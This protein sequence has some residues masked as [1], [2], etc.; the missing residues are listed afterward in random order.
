M[1]VCLLS[2][3]QKMMESLNNEIKM[4]QNK[5]NPESSRLSGFFSFLYLFLLFSP[6]LHDLLILSLRL[7]ED[8]DTEDSTDHGTRDARPHKHL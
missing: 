2:S 8:L 6:L 5:K 7:E 4:Y 3:W 1:G